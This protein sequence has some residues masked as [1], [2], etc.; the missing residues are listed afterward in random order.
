[1]V[2]WFLDLRI[3][4]NSFTSFSAHKYEDL[5]KISPQYHPFFGVFLAV[6]AS[7][8]LCNKKSPTKQ[9]KDHPKK[10]NQVES[11]STSTTIQ[12]ISERKNRFKGDGDNLEFKKF[13]ERRGGSE[14]DGKPRFRALDSLLNSKPG[15]EETS[16]RHYY[17]NLNDYMIIHD[18]IWLHAWCWHD[19]SGVHFLWK[20]DIET[21][22]IVE[23]V[24][25]CAN[26][27]T[28]TSRKKKNDRFAL[29]L[30]SSSSGLVATH[31][32]QCSQ[33]R[34]IIEALFSFL[35]RREERLEGTNRIFQIMN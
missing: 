26:F 18:Y 19:V 11:G 16:Y 33:R 9:Q 8:N 21:I 2:I 20:I 10:G 22:A 6:G 13:S 17:S 29:C 25:F 31:P 32:L 14:P 23:L 28:A 15:R 35:S 30:R 27:V 34:R 1:M 24:N 4:S 3:L 7:T 12:L 5:L